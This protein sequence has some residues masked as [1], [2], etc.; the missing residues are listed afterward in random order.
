M[1]PPHF[2]VLYAEYEALI[3]IRTL[4]IIKGELPN[5]ALALA[6]EWASEHRVELME[7]WDLCAQMQTPKKVPPLK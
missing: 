3:D 1:P 7:D 5:R 6:L 4:E 2:H